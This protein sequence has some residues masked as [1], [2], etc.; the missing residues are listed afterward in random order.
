MSGVNSEFSLGNTP[1]FHIDGGELYY[2]AKNEYKLTFN[3]L[4]PFIGQPEGGIKLSDDTK[5]LAQDAEL[6]ALTLVLAQPKVK[7]VLRRGGSTVPYEASSVYIKKESDIV[8]VVFLQ[9]DMGM[10]SAILFN[11]I[12]SF[13]EYFAA[14]N[15]SLVTLP[16]VNLIKPKLS[17]EALIFIFNLTDCYRRAYLNEMLAN[18]TKLVEAIYEDEFIAILEQELKSNDIRWLLPSLIR[19]VPGLSE[20]T[21]EFKGEDLEIAESMDFISRA[22]TSSDKRPI[23]YL[24]SS[25]KYMGLEFTLFWKYAV[26]FEVTVLNN[27]TGMGDTIGRYYL[28]PTDEANHLISFSPSEGG[29]KL[30]HLALTSAEMVTELKK[31]IEAYYA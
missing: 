6:A 11:G 19:L 8:R 5:Q 25:G 27:S 10:L 7:L 4:S 1:I 28:A 29:T 22:T 17:L 31:I 20:I 23:Y 3:S 24:G 21:L 14:Q 16:P 2:L 18:S 12:D 26:G 30:T 13:C 15:C 9:E